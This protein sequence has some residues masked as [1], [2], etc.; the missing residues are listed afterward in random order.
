MQKTAIFVPTKPVIVRGSVE[1]LH[2]VI[3][4]SA[5]RGDVR[6]LLAAFPEESFFCFHKKHSVPLELATALTPF[7]TGKME[8]DGHLICEVDCGRACQNATAFI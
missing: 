1:E 8:I 2:E 6:E 7:H 3:S 4:G 5:C